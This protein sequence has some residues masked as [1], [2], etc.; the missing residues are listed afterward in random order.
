MRATGATPA[1]ACD[2]WRVRLLMGLVAAAT[3]ALCVIAT[4]ALARDSLAPPGAPDQWLPRQD[5]VYRH[6][7]PFDAASATRELGLAPGQLEALHF[8]D[9]RSIVQLARALQLDVGALRDRLVAPALVGVTDPRR[10]ARLRSRAWRMMSQGHPAQHLLYHP[11]HGLDVRTNTRRTFGIGPLAYIRARLRGFT[12][13][14]LARAN[15][16]GLPELAA[17]LEDLFAVDHDEGLRLQVTSAAAAAERR[18]VRRSHVPCWSKRTI[19]GS[20]PAHPYAA[21]HRLKKRV[22]LPRTRAQLRADEALM[23]R[24]RTTRPASCWTVP[25]PWR[26]PDL[27]PAPASDPDPDPTMRGFVDPATPAEERRAVPRAVCLLA[28]S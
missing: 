27:E 10:V 22:L 24:F 26:G 15:G 21:Q 17:D 2:A 18:A 3:A 13:R 11:Y 28:S 9:R 7:L 6:W 23:E 5:W 16:L 4:S 12:P 14:A 1:A 19:P 20:D 25:D 8:D